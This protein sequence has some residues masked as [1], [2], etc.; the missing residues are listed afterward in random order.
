MTIAI[1][2][3]QGRVSPVFDVAINLLLIGVADGR[4]IQRQERRL[5]GTDPPARVAEFLTL[6]AEVLICGAISAPLEARLTASGVQV[7][8]F[9]CGAVD[10]VLAA[11]LNGDLASRE[12]AM[13]GCRGR[14]RQEG[15]RVMPRGFGM[16]AGRRGRRGQGHGQGAGRMGGPRAAGPGGFCVCPRCGEKVPHVAGQPCMQVSCP[17]CGTPMTRA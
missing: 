4:E 15:E 5:F 12:F 16:G 13:P 7:I 6:G 3:W 17:K 10:E 11:Y 8:G 2:Q 9:T 1:P 14:Q